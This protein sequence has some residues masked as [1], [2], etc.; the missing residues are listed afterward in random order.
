MTFNTKAKCILEKHPLQ[1]VTNFLNSVEAG[2]F[3][4][5]TQEAFSNL[6][7]RS[8]DDHVMSEARK[9]VKSLQNLVEHP[10]FSNRSDDIYPAI[11]NIQSVIDWN[12]QNKP[13]G[14]PGSLSQADTLCLQWLK[15]SYIKHFPEQSPSF[16]KG[17]LLN[18]LGIALLDK[19][20]P[21]STDSQLE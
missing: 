3:I 21:N 9:A 20:L 13:K 7:Y 11:D 1:T 19:E 15:G 10:L 4:G 18:K 16:E 2:D 12:D 17:T 8:S 6:R 14:R 5:A